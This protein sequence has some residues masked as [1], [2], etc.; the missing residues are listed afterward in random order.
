[1][2]SL[3]IISLSELEKASPQE[4]KKLYD[5]CYEHGFFYL[6][7]HGVSPEIINPTIEASRKFFKLPEDVKENYGHD[8]QKVYPKTSRGYVPL[9]GEALNQNAGQDP[10]ELFDLGIDK[11]QPDDPLQTP[12]TGENVMPNDS[13]APGFSS[14]HYQ[15]Q[16]EIMTK[17]VPKLLKGLALALE[18]EENWFDKYFTDPTLIH[19]T[20]YY[21]PGFGK[22]GKH[23]DTGIFTV[24]IQEYFPTPSLRVYTKD[25]WIDVP[26]VEDAFVINLGDMLQYWT[27]G[28][29]V[30]TAHEVIHNRPT[31]R[32]SI[33]IFVF[34]NIETIIE[35]FGTTEKI[36]SKEVML[37]N[38]LSIWETGEGSGRAKELV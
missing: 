13:V 12:F 1:M 28:L 32:V 6:K 27:D 26:C 31:D 11:K 29:F 17:V 22:A 24:L 33:P 7:E 2:K 3:P 4:I 14:S 10:K 38:F 30:S 25:K 19:R 15:L 23:T 34:P 9:F 37:S 16:N 5:V 35:P 36:S 20:V 8:I 21:P 18:L